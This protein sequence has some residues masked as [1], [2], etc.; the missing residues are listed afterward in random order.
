MSLLLLPTDQGSVFQPYSAARES[1]NALFVHGDYVYQLPRVAV[2]N[3][4]RLCGLERQKFI[5]SQFRRP[6]SVE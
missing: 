3:H 4:H 6:K 2:M 1:G 5:L